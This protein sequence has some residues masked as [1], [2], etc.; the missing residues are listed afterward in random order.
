MAEVAIAV[1]LSG[2]GWIFH[3]LVHFGHL[4]HSAKK[5]AFHQL[6]VYF[7]MKKAS[8]EDLA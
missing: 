4:A 2:I 8:A 1:R 7:V 5:I 6:I 3:G